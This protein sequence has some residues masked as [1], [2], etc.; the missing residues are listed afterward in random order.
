MI[1]GIPWPIFL[2]GV[3]FILAVGWFIIS[4]IV[5]AVH[6]PMANEAAIDD[7][8]QELRHEAKQS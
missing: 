2:G 6:P 1:R 4:C 3:L 7:A 5:D 8:A